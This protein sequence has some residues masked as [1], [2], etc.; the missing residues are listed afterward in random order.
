MAMA[1]TMLTT[2]PPCGHA[3]GH[4]CFHHSHPAMCSYVYRPAP[5]AVEATVAESSCRASSG[6]NL[7]DTGAYCFATVHHRYRCYACRPY[8]MAVRPRYDMVSK[9]VRNTGAWEPKISSPQALLELAARIIGRPIALHGQTT[10]LDIGSNLGYFTLQ[11]AH[12]G[13]DVLAVEPMS[14][15]RNA[16]E[17]SMCVSAGASAQTVGDGF[18]ASD[19]IRLISAALTSPAAA[20][21]DGGACILRSDAANLG[22]GHLTCGAQARPCH[23]S[24]RAMCEAVPLTTLDRL[25]R[26]L[27][28]GLRHGAKP[29]VGTLIDIVKMD[30]E[31]LECQVLEG[32]SHLFTRFRP[33]LFL[34]EGKDSHSRACALST[35][36]RFNYTV[37]ALKDRDHNLLWVRG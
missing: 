34:M 27:Q 12:A 14:H 2:T 1:A 19:K 18:R 10:F 35:A 16:L 25:L 37:H 17:L 4:A 3:D 22:N 20:S 9:V 6:V 30:V 33:S 24:E 31:G 15:N 7:S 11:F 8:A 21:I 23:E 28:L 5:S 26:D 13:W 32:A 29:W 36:A